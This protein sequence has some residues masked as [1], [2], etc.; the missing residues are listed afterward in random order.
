MRKVM[1]TIGNRSVH[2]ISWRPFSHNGLSL[3]AVIPHV[4]HNR[5]IGRVT[6][7]FAWVSVMRIFSSAF[8]YSIPIDI[9]MDNL[10]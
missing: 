10:A 3:E 4:R 1:H 8:L 7:A 5:L 6:F 2:L 9:L